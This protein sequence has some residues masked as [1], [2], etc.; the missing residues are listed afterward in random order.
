MITGNGAELLIYD[1]ET[2]KYVSMMKHLNPYGEKAFDECVFVDLK[3]GDNELLLRSYNRF[4]REHTMQ[5]ELHQE[6]T[7]FTQTVMFDEPLAPYRY[8][9]VRVTNSDNPS[10]HTDC[11]LHNLEIDLIH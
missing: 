4:E 9:L 3:K 8:Y 2:G 11:K 5:I 1:N 7:E 6:Q 10:E